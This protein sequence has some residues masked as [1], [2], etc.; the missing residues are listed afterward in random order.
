MKK[1]KVFGKEMEVNG[2][3]RNPQY[4]ESSY[5]LGSSGSGK[6]I[7]LSDGTSLNR[8]SK[9]GFL[10]LKD[11]QSGDIFLLDLYGYDGYNH[12]YELKSQVQHVDTST[13]K[14]STSVV[15][16]AYG[17][18]DAFKCLKE[19]YRKDPKDYS[20]VI[21]ESKEK[22]SDWVYYNGKIGNTRAN[23]VGKGPLE[24]DDMAKIKHVHVL[25]DSLDKS[26]VSGKPSIMK[27]K[28]LVVEEI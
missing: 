7:L 1:M 26:I 19:V 10:A 5:F 16:N 18:N 21:L 25:I 20:L 2:Y 8:D 24:R 15:V 28:E 11:T 27:L 14:K 3:T 4:F 17:M 13:R 23:Y 22:Y 9:Y 6:P 12:T